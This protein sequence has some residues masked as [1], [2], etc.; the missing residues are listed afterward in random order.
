MPKPLIAVTTS[1]RS[2]WRIFPLVA[3]NVWLAGGRSV[4]WGTGRDADLDKVDGLIIGGGDDVSPEL[5]GG[6]LTASARIEP[7]R[8]T[9]ERS[10]ACTAL[11]RDIP[12][13]GICRGAQMLNIALGG[14][15]HQDAWHAFPN[16]KLVK[17]ILPKRQVQITPD[18]H[19]ARYAG[20][21]D[22]TVNALHTQAI[23][24]LGEDL[25]VN[26]RDTAGMIQGIE[27]QRDPFALGVQWH[28]EHLFYARR[29]RRIFAALV[30]AARAYAADR[31]QIGAVAAT[32]YARSAG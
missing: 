27:R 18:T 25:R 4:R 6:K 26:A 3:F 1:R 28:P 23:N 22:M 7:A 14:T 19:L 2:G 10:L 11:K 5:Y 9:L 12:V 16:A 15:L 8:D 30:T 13:L 31:G 17:T 21:K 20:D 24:V 29:Q 32:A